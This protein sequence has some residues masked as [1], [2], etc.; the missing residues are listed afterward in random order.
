MAS[1]KSLET[2]IEEARKMH[3][4]LDFSLVKSY[5]NNN[6]E[7]NVICHKKDYAN[8][9]HGV[10]KITPLNLLNGKSCPKCCGKNFTSDDR[11]LFCSIKH[12]YKYDYSKSD[13]SSVKNKTIVI[14]GKHGEFKIDYDHHFNGNIGCLYCSYES[15]DTNSFIEK[16]KKIHN[17]FYTYD[18]VEYKNSHEKIVVTCPI[19]GD[20]HQTPNAHLNGQGCPKC[21]SGRIVLEDKVSKALNENGIPYTKN[22]RPKWL[23][24]ESKGQLSL[25][26]YLPKCNVAIECQ[27]KQHFGLGGWGKK[28]DFDRQFER[29]KWKLEQCKINTVDLVYFANKRDITTPYIGKIFTDVNE[30]MEYIRYGNNIGVAQSETFSL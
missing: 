1:R 4:D 16:A 21:G 13:F 14:C 24:T 2:F 7:V 12:D 8:R 20:F 22:E 28:F 10:F 19:H 17:D 23:K 25:D 29:D 26:F 9:E 15:R 18:K 6:T 5:T 30:L 27:G 11:K 3:N